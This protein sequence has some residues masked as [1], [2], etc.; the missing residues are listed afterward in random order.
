M[1]ETE[2]TSSTIEPDSLPDDSQYKY[3]LK[4]K[5]KKSRNRN[6]NQEKPATIYQ[7]FGTTELSVVNNKYNFRTPPSYEHEN[8]HD[9]NR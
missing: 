1:R 3:R 7:I 5:N 2:M 9:F 6:F 4:N 8:N